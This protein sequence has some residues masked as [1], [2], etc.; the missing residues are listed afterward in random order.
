[1]PVVTT[2]VVLKLVP[3]LMGPAGVQALARLWGRPESCK[4]YRLAGREQDT[5]VMA[6]L[7]ASRHESLSEIHER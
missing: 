6:R 5:R 7:R 3:N 4:T 1:M 2:N